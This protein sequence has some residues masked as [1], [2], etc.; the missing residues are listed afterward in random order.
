MGFVVGGGDGEDG[1]LGVAAALTLQA[2]LAFFV[3]NVPSS[4][5]L[6]LL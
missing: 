1:S 2:L 6:T 3:A 4:Y 5:F